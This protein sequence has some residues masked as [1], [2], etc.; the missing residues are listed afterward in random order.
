[1][2]EE[3]AV[4]HLFA[5]AQAQLGPLWGLVNNAGIT[6][7]ATRLED[8]TAEEFDLVAKAPD[9]GLSHPHFEPT[10]MVARRI[11]RKI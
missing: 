10:S 8:L 6:G 1:M 4:S 3:A 5:Q 7:G 11:I 9:R 2:A